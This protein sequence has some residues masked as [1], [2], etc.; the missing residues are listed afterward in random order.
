[1]KLKEFATYINPLEE[2][3]LVFPNQEI[4]TQVSIF[5]GPWGDCEVTQGSV[6]IGNTKGNLIIRVDYPI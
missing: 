5:E 4:L 6:S 3:C 2:V 1:M